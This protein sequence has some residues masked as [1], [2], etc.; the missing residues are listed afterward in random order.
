M[1]PA[2]PGPGMYFVTAWQRAAKHE[3][4]SGRGGVR[5]RSSA[6]RRVDHPRRRVLAGAGDTRSRT[7]T[8]WS[9][10]SRPR[11]S[12]AIYQKSKLALARRRTCRGTACAAE[13]SRPS[14]GSGSYCLVSV[15]AN[16]D[17][18][19]PAVFA[20]ATIEAFE[21][22]EE[23]PV[24]KCFFSITRDEMNHEECCQRSIAALWPG[25]PLSWS[26]S[27][28]LERAAHNTYRFSRGGHFFVLTKKFFWFLPF[29]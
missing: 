7:S 15:L 4:R 29:K 2:L 24:R 9:G 22:H 12:A 19:G 26:P 18:S 1:V 25:G 8:R 28:D 14:S 17:A 10:G 23:D 3:G 11:S 16:F 6:A 5:E 20:R 13:T 21:K 27:T